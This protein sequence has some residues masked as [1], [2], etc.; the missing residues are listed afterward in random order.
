VVVVEQ[1]LRL[2]HRV[3]PVAF[4]CSYC[5]LCARVRKRVRQV[6]V[7]VSAL[8]AMFYGEDVTLLVAMVFDGAGKQSGVDVGVLRVG[9]RASEST[10]FGGGLGR[11][12]PNCD[13]RAVALAMLPL[14]LDIAYR[15]WN[16]LSWTFGFLVSVLHEHASL[17]TQQCSERKYKVSG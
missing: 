7:N 6:V 3:L 16:V 12:C 17:T 4:G 5:Y 11:G 9:G 10:M 8:V 1:A 2:L 15:C 14:H 13:T